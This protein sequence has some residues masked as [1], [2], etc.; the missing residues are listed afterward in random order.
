M[1]CDR[2]EEK[3]CKCH[4]HCGNVIQRLI[5]Q[6]TLSIKTNNS[7]LHNISR[8]SD[9][10]HNIILQDPNLLCGASTSATHKVN[11]SV[12]DDTLSQPLDSVQNQCN[13]HVHK[14]RFNINFPL[15]LGLPVATSFQN[16]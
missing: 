14:I 13:P 10:L 11:K 8:V 9:W 3:I 6:I 4:T 7:A 12:L 5:L 16:I 1:R 2:L 15:C